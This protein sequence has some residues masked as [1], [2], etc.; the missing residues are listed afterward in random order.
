MSAPLYTARHGLIWA[1]AGGNV[2]TI[3]EATEA[4]PVLLDMALSERD[5]DLAAS[6]IAR[7]G[8]LTR[9]VRE[10]KEQAVNQPLEQ[11]A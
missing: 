6:W 7:L 1:S 5:A 4:L 10:A 2:R 11:A 9:A 8:D 3:R